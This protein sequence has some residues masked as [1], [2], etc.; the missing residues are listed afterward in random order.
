MCLAIMLH[1]FVQ[2]DKIVK[3]IIAGAINAIRILIAHMIGKDVSKI[4]ALIDA[5]CLN[6]PY[7]SLGN[8]VISNLMENAS[9]IRIAKMIGVVSDSNVLM[10]VSRRDA[11][12]DTVVGKENVKEIDHLK[13]Y[14]L[15]FIY[16]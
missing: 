11:H 6:V 3:D 1:L 4:N 10:N 15:L 5:N 7:A 13:N 14:Y 8:V 16:I 2:Q 9:L 12:L